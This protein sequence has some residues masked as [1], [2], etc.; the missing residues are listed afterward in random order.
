MCYNYFCN[1]YGI[2]DWFKHNHH[3]GLQQ[4]YLANYRCH[5]YCNGVIYN[6]H[7]FNRHD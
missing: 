6:Y 4:L 5:I 7:P 2:S 3:V 1:H